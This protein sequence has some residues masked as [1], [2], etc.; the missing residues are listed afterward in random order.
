MIGILVTI[1]IIVYLA[2]QAV[3]YD[4]SPWRWGIFALFFSLLALGIFMYQTERK[5]WGF[6]WISVWAVA[7]IVNLFHGRLL[8]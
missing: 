3:N 8:L 7:E 1:T 2:R 4:K 6:I 5:S